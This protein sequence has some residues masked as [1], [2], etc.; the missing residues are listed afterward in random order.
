MKDRTSINVRTAKIL[1]LK[2]MPHL[3]Y[4]LLLSFTYRTHSVR[5]QALKLV[6]R[7]ELLYYGKSYLDLQKLGL[8]SHS[9]SNMQLNIE[10]QLKLH[11]HHT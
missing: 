1:A 2:L 5:I 11:V 3:I 4:L 7:K 9:S 10:G 6:R 8:V